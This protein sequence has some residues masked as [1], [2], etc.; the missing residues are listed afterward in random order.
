MLKPWVPLG[1]SLGLGTYHSS[2]AGYPESHRDPHVSTYL[3]LGFQ[4]YAITSAF[5]YCGYR[6]SCLAS[7]RFAYWAP[8][9]AWDV[10]FNVS[11][12]GW[13]RILWLARNSLSPCVFALTLWPY[14]WQSRGLSW[15][16]PCVSGFG[17]C[18]WGESSLYCNR[19]K[20][21]CDLLHSETSI[22]WYSLTSLCWE[23]YL[24]SR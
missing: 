19:N 23:G 21:S 1:P 11:W 15:P 12:L 7:K 16:V 3:A 17:S 14:A 10:V 5:I 4:T 24:M 6:P 22:G 8:S 2:S 18:G 13:C 9:P 20:S